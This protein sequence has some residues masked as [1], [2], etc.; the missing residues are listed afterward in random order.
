MPDASP[1]D[2]LAGFKTSDLMR[3]YYGAG[4]M[5][6]SH[7]HHRTTQAS[8]SPTL[9]LPSGCSMAMVRR[10]TPC[11]S[12]HPSSPTDSKLPQADASF[13][14]RREF[15]FTMDGDV[16]VRYL[17]FK[18]CHPSMHTVPPSHHHAFLTGWRRT[19]AGHRRP[20]P[21]QNRH[22]PRI[23]HRPTAPP[24]LQGLCQG[25]WPGGARAG[26]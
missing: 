22:W 26:L 19:A 5:G 17:A 23:Q 20:L 25:L 13:F 10:T 15:C 24:G 2:A 8:S 1:A 21:L 6:A 18:V 9:C 12:A 7:A 14:K 11:Y 4:C 16:F 3:A